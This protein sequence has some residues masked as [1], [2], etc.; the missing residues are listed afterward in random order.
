MQPSHR[1]VVIT[2]IG[3]LSPVGNDWKSF[4]DAIQAGRSGIGTITQFDLQ[5]FPVTMAGEVKD[6]ALGNHV[7]LK[8]V[9]SLKRLARH[10]QL[11]IAASW[12]AIRH[13]GLTPESLRTQSGVMVR[14]GL[15]TGAIDVIEQ[16]KSEL[17]GKGPRKVSPHIVPASVPHAVA[18]EL[19]LSLGID[20]SRGTISSACPSGLEAV[21]AGAAVLRSGR[22]DLVIA[23][24]A[25]A[26]ITPLTMATLC[27]CGLAS[28][29]PFPP[30]RASRPFDARR[31]GGLIGEGACMLVLETLDHALDR[32]VEPL[33]EILSHG[34][35]GDSPEGDDCDGLAVA[36]RQALSE[37]ALLPVDIDYI[38]A[39]GP[40]HPRI[41]RAEVQQI[42][43]VFGAHAWRIPVSSIK[44][45]IG[46]PFAAAG[47]MQ[48]AATTLAMRGGW[49]PPTANYTYPDPDCDLNV[50]PN[51][52]VRMPMERALINMHGMGG[53][54]SCMIL[55]KG[56]DG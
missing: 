27:R 9:S 30:E 33:A 55:G 34:E 31:A 54:N 48:V 14:L 21:A 26:P 42:K 18:N 51:H 3:I 25:D 13:A 53:G 1:R 50:V 45:S 20:C 17:A 11:G 38:N 5:D 16:G 35:W 19:V 6:F 49:V 4:R 22:A 2:G 15:S 44:G 36:M 56:T 32:G 7:D 37:A 43:K 23:G 10:T 52:A 24:G 40:S 29:C 47:P 41:D 39:H 8:R 12:D 28:E 46:N